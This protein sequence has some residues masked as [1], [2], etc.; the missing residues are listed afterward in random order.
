MLPI[1]IFFKFFKGA[2]ELPVQ[3]VIAP[4]RGGVP[5]KLKRRRSEKIPAGYSLKEWLDLRALYGDRAREVARSRSLLSPQADAAPKAGVIAR[6]APSIPDDVDL[7]VAARSR[8]RDEEFVIM[9]LM[10]SFYAR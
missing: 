4:Q 1:L 5:P 8:D 3:E 7:H 9:M 10:I 2:S 6:E